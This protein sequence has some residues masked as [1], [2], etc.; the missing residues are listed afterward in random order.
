MTEIELKVLNINKKE[1]IKKLEKLGAKIISDEQQI[2]TIYDDKKGTI[3]SLNTRS[4][5]RIRETN[6]K[7]RRLEKS[8]FTF[9][10]LITDN[11][12]RKSEEINVSIDSKDNLEKILSYLGFYKKHMGKKHRI[13][14]ELENIRFDIDEWDK[15]TYPYPYLEIESDDEIAIQKIIKTLNIKE[16]DIS[17]KS[18]TELRREIGLE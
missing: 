2:N 14:Y 3:S 17:T 11:G 16:E 4:Y 18:I 6:D 1:I 15:E 8:T 13:S 7:I 10:K 9:K 12:I 5:M